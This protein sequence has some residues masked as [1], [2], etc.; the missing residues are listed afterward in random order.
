MPNSVSPFKLDANITSAEHRC[1]MIELAI[2]SDERL[3]MTRYEIEKQGISYTYDTLNEL[4]AIYDARLYFVLGFDSVVAIDSWYRGESILK[5]FPLITALRPGVDNSLGTKKI[6]EYRKTY[7]AEIHILHMP[8]IDCSSS[9]IRELCRNG[10]S[11]TGLVS[12][13]VEEYIIKNG[14]YKD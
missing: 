12:E 11:I 14:L 2:A 9:Q 8:P 5:E 6:A 4:T 10:G 1:N 13:N 7:N 3:E